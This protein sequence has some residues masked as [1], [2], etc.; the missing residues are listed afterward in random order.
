MTATENFF[1]ELGRRGNEPRLSMISGSVRCDLTRGEQTNHWHIKIR[2]GD[3]EVSRVDARA[4]G[5]IRTDEAL[6]DHLA[7]GEM[8]LT[9]SYLRGAAVIE[10][11]FELICVFERLFPGPPGRGEGRLPVSAGRG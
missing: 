9:T 4:D 1:E 10:G 7:T 3:I 8:N 2:N 6:F 11:D 5:V